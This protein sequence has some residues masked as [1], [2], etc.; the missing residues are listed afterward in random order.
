VRSEM[1]WYE[2][3]GADRAG[4]VFVLSSSGGCYRRG[5]R[6]NLR[7]LQKPGQR[8]LT[9]LSRGPGALA[10]GGLASRDETGGWV[11]EGFRLHYLD[12]CYS[13]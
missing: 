12:E 13:R 9:R 11:S 10:S 4:A 1:R 7:R 8:P 5:Q 2:R 3:A 6:S